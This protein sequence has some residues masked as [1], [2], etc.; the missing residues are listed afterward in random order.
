MKKKHLYSTE[1]ILQQLDESARNFTFPM[2]DNGYCYPAD[3]R[4]HAYR[5]DS[6]WALVIECVGWNP[7]AGGTQTILHCYGNCLKRLPGTANEDFLHLLEDGPEG[8]LFDEEYGEYVR[9]EA[10]T[11]RI[12]RKVVRIN[13]NTDFFAAKGIEL[14]EPPKVHGFEL[15]RSL[16]PE[17]RDLLLATEE[18]LRQ[19][20]PP[21]LP[22]LLRLDEWNHPDLCADELPS[23]T[24]TFQMIAEALASGDA[25]RYAPLKPS[26]TYWRNWP[27]GGTL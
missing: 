10:R 25:A 3:V 15:L 5:D 16:L 27:E 23:D 14:I 8:P 26:N 4:L 18:E 19:R 11:A 20:V 6:R 7:R 9:D 22:C 24:E 13:T 2:L 21:D 17:H 12:R 1:D